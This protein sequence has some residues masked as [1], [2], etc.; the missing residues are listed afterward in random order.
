MESEVFTA[1]GM[2]SSGMRPRET[3]LCYLRFVIRV[4]A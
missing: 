1:T 3:V 2:S 4:D